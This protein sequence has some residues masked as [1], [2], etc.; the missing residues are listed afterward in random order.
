MI[1]DNPVMI[2]AGKR[3]FN[4]AFTTERSIGITAVKRENFYSKSYSVTLVEKL[5]SSTVHPVM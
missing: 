4:T 2:D 1:K 5:G 3:F